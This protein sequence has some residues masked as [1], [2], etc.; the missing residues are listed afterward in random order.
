MTCLLLLLAYCEARLVS[1]CLRYDFIA[2]AT[3]LISPDSNLHQITE[4]YASVLLESINVSKTTRL[5][6][7]IIGYNQPLH[8]CY[9]AHLNNTQDITLTGG[10]KPYRHKTYQIVIE[11]RKDYKG[12]FAF[13]SAKKV[14]EQ[15]IIDRQN[16]CA[17][18]IR[19]YEYADQPN[20]STAEAILSNL[21]DGTT[22]LDR[23][24][25]KNIQ[26]AWLYCFKASN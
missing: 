7:K 2:R 11:E 15:A 5:A 10:K 1:S 23:N 24:C 19:P 20:I 9:T 26:L 6:V 3:I 21:D 16:H 4:I 17:K 12:Q 14:V 13:Y 25:G 8:M 22:M 18:D